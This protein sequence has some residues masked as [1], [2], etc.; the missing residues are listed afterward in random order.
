M[1]ERTSGLIL[2]ADDESDIRDL[3]RIFLEREGYDI[4]E[5]TNGQEALDSARRNA[6]RLSLIILDIMMPELDGIRAAKQIRELTDVP[7]LFLTAL[8]SDKN[9]NEA[10]A[11]GG[12]DY[13]VK[14][15]RAT[16]LVLKVRALIK[17][18]RMYLDALRNS[19]VHSDELVW[20]GQDCVFYPE[21]KRVVR[22]GYEIQLTDRECQLLECL[23]AHRGN[24]VTTDQLYEAVWMEPYLATMSNTVIVHIA[25]LRRK[26][27]D[28]PSRPELIRTVWGRGYKID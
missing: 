17:R 2:I 28:N 18:Y 6:G 15:F 19:D 14:P 23:F 4:L 16:D 22:K 9:K 20:H 27:E 3:L 1:E 26:L 10:Y 7:I 21:K 5:A 11:L 8:S 13:M 12:D 24:A 25:N